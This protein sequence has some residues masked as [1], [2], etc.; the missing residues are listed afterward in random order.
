M[1]IIIT[2]FSLFTFS[3][4]VDAS[5]KHHITKVELNEYIGYVNWVNNCTSSIILVNKVSREVI[6]TIS[7]DGDTDNLSVEL[8][9]HQA[10]IRNT[11]YD[12]LKLK[13]C[14]NDGHKDLW[15]LLSWGAREGQE[16]YKIWRY[17]PRRK[18]F[19]YYIYSRH[20]RLETS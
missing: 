2:L 13:D 9:T 4:V 8:I 7:L 17:N 10:K 20:G 1:R 12:Y 18:N 16:T 5:N 6:Q 3:V 14:D 19:Q 11:N 15:L